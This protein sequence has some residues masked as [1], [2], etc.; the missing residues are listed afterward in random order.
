M[1]TGS[2][3]LGRGLKTKVKQ[4]R[5]E[6]DLLLKTTTKQSKSQEGRRVIRFSTF[7]TLFQPTIIARGRLPARPIPCARFVVKEPFD[8]G[9]YYC[10]V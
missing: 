6:T 1:G 9:T 4:G 5:D 8:R 7:N 10:C 2:A 3:R